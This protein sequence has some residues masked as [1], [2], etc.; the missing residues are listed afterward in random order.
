METLLLSANSQLLPRSARQ[1][2]FRT[3]NVMFLYTTSSTFD[4][5]VGCV[6][7]TSPK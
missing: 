5:I 6:S 7:T 1:R 3:S 4:P 2:D